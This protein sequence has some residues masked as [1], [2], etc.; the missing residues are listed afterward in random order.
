[1]LDMNHFMKDIQK[2]QNL[3]DEIS[4]ERDRLQEKMLIDGNMTEKEQIQFELLEHLMDT[5]R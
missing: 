3:V 4:A 2:L 1:M 5:M